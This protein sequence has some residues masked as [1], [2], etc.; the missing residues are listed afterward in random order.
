VPKHPRSSLG[1]VKL[2]LIVNDL[3]RKRTVETRRIKLGLR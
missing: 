2:R 1:A 3:R